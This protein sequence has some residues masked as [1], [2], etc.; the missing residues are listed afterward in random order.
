VSLFEFVSVMVSIILGLSLAQLLGGIARLARDP[1]RISLFAPHTVWVGTLILVHSLLW[2]SVWDFHDVE[3]NYARFLTINSAPLILFFV[4]SLIIP[5]RDESGL[6][7]SKAHF[8]Q[9]RV[10]LMAAW[11]ALEMIFIFDGPVVFGVEPMLLPA[12][13]F[14]QVAGL[15]AATW[16]LWTRS[17]RAHSVIAWVVF[18]LVALGGLRRFLPGAVMPA[19]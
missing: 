6:A 1:K 3:W 18:V 19:T 4:S 14:G 7:D 9:I 5:N 2:W 13:R 8:F 12:V 17:P 16:G 11:V 15:V 10:L